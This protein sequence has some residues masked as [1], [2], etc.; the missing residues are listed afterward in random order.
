MRPS[1][2]RTREK[3]GCV[4]NRLLCA[5][6]LVVGVGLPLAAQEL[7]Q[8][9][10]EARGSSGPSSH[11]DDSTPPVGSLA[12]LSSRVKPTNRLYVRKTNGEEISGRFLAASEISL[13][14][15]IEGQARE[16]SA[17]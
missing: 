5:F 15:E 4:G 8:P 3:A 7:P 9:E 1:R 2:R 14:L 17:S 13:T 16:I 6:V 11:G 12:A 10:S